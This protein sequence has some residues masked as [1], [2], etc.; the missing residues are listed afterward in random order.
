MNFNSS[1]LP[2]SLHPVFDN[3]WPRFVLLVFLLFLI[4][5]T[6]AVS[7]AGVTIKFSHVAAIDTPKGQAALFF[8]N[9]V[10]HRSKGD[11]RVEIYPNASLYSDREAIEALALNALQMAAPVF[12]NF[13]RFSPELQLFDLPFLFNDTSHLHRALDGALGK[14]LLT[15][16][17]RR[18]LIGL[19]FWDAG[20]K[21]LTANIPLI[22]PGDTAGLKFRITNSRV[23][24]AQFEALSAEP[25]VLP[26]AETY[27]ALQHKV[28]DGQE[29][30]LTNIFEK[31]LFQ[32]QTDLTLTNH[33]YLGYLV[34]TN[35]IFWNQLSSRQKDIITSSMTDATEFIRH[36]AVE[37]NQRS[38]AAIKASRK[39][40]IHELTRE[41]RRIW[42]AKLQTIY[43]D[44]Y[45]EIGRDLIKQAQEQAE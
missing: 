17:S 26:F 23:L 8:K 36:K 16:V 31:K 5:A 10:E 25:R 32:V 13:T 39:T 22:K 37:L 21:Q 45:Q 19:G 12:S 30:T 38:L 28:I 4:P 11:I 2:A 35:E 7:A 24:Q 3:G 44:F 9:L 41:Q 14:T 18:G 43:P 34:V 15:S 6:P 20:F 29:N 1:K 33:G 40:V 27:G 42:R